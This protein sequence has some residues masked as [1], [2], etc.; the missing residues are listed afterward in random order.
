[1]LGGWYLASN[2]TTNSV[3][4]VE[5]HNPQTIAVTIASQIN[6]ADI[7]TIATFTAISAKAITPC[8]ANRL[9][10]SNVINNPTTTLINTIGTVARIING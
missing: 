7:C 6:P 10:G 8:I 1:M 3:N 9:C 2:G 5:K 4:S